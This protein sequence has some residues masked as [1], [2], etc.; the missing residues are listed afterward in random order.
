MSKQHIK[1]RLI[2]EVGYH[3]LDFGCDDFDRAEYNRYIIK[4]KLFIIGYILAEEAVNHTPFTQPLAK[5]IPV[6]YELR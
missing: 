4:Q 3:C 5:W 6:G 1:F 2:D